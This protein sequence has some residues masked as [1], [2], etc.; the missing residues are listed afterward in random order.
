[1]SPAQYVAELMKPGGMSAVRTETLRVELASAAPAWLAEFFAADG[2]VGVAAALLVHLEPGALLAGLA[3]AMDLVVNSVDAAMRTER[4]L[5][6]VVESPDFIS[7]V[8]LAYGRCV[9]SSSRVAPAVETTRGVPL[10]PPAP[11]SAAAWAE[12]RVRLRIRTA[13]LQVMTMLVASEEC[14]EAGLT[15]VA[16]SMEEVERD[17]GVSKA[18]GLLVEDLAAPLPPPSAADADSDLVEAVWEERAAVAT[19][20]QQV[21]ANAPTLELRCQQRGLLALCG[22]DAVMATLE[23]DLASVERV[24]ASAPSPTGPRR[25]GHTRSGASALPSEAQQRR[26]RVERHVSTIREQMEAY[27]E[28]SAAD[29]AAATDA[30]SGVQLTDPGAL[31]AGIMAAAASAGRYSEAVTV[32]QQLMALG[33]VGRQR[34][35]AAGLWDALAS[36]TTAAV[37]G[38]EAAA[39]SVAAAVLAPMDGVAVVLAQARQVEV[40]TSKLAAAESAAAAASVAGAGATAAAAEVAA[41]TARLRDAEVRCHYVVSYMRFVISTPT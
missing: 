25:S 2:M 4:G 35:A 28:D 24:V 18:Y 12:E 1:M 23:P 16:G 27:R 40:L 15:A 37:L 31:A 7:A 11:L 33:T 21:V 36:A 14:G 32:L 30:G 13:A 41:L 29:D 26:M 19:Y 39:S 6:V 22:L 9:V 38:A 20:L 34:E 8:V 17:L 10:R 5:A 3:A